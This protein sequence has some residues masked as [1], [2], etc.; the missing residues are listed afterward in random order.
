[1]NVFNYN[2]L[3]RH[4]FYIVRSYVV[5]FDK[6][7]TLIS[8]LFTVNLAFFWLSYVASCNLNSAAHNNDK[9]DALENQ[10]LMF[11]RL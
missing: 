6:N 9:N 2:Y 4:H 11:S 10:L 5:C 8:L 3:S 1:M 7:S